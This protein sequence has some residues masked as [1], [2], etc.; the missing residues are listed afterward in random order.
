MILM[1]PV[2]NE[3]TKQ[4]FVSAEEVA[5]FA[6]GYPH[7]SRTEI[8]LSSYLIPGKEIPL[9]DL[10]VTQHFGKDSNK[11]I[12]LSSLN[13]DEVLVLIEKDEIKEYLPVKVRFHPG[14]G[15]LP[16]PDLSHQVRR[17]I[18]STTLWNDPTLRLITT[19]GCESSFS[20][21]IRIAVSIN[22]KFDAE[23]G[24]M[25]FDSADVGIDNSKYNVSLAGVSL[26]IRLTM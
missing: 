11:K 4:Y 22:A 23:N 5:P 9:H 6:V 24:K 3:E 26:T 21:H 18:F 12:D 1:S 20:D 19:G 25:S 8:H 2:Y 10:V 16:H 13:L 7:T 17:L 14:S 15:F